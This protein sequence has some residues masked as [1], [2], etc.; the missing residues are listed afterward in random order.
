LS[1]YKSRL[2][3]NG[4]NQAFGRDYWETYAPVVAWSTIH[5][6][7][8]F[9]TLL[10]LKTRQVDYTSA[11]P[12]ADLD[13]PVFMK[14]PQ[15]WYVNSSGVLSQHSDPKHHDTTHFLHLKKNLHGCK[16]A[17][18]N[19]FKMLSEGLRHLGFVHSATDSCLFLRS[20]C[21]IVVYVDDC[22]FFHSLIQ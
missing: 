15:G 5:L 14:V 7:L 11:F 4:K 16:Q 21:I 18:R 22:L 1:K 13:V 10:P 3:V 8:Y 17:A 19:S 9:S 12:Q 20:D 6:L 2:C